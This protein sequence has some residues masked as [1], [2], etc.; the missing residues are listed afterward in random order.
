MSKELEKRI[1]EELSQY[2]KG[3]LFFAKMCD[4]NSFRKQA[5]RLFEFLEETKVAAIKQKLREVTTVVLI[6]LTTALVFFSVLSTTVVP[7]LAEI[8][9]PVVFMI[10]AGFVFELLFLLEFRVYLSYRASME[11]IRRQRF[12]EG[13]ESE[14]KAYLGSNV[15][16]IP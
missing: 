10:M 14:I 3:L 1:E 6:A 2:K 5:A 12:I 8:R 7:K 15:C 9:V 13:I 16:G 11:K 4:W